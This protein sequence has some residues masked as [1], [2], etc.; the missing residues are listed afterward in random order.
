MATHLDILRQEAA[1]LP[2]TPGVYFW[3]NEDGRVLYIGKA[4]NLRA[5]V[6]SYFS[7]AQRDRRTRK[8]L[9]EARHIEYELTSTELEALFRESA[10][11]K[12]VLPE[13][14]RALRRPKA[15][16]YL[17][18]DLSRP[19][20]FMEIARGKLDDGALYFGPFPSGAITRETMA[21]LHDVLPLRKCTAAKPRCKP[22][23][24]FQMGKCAAP[25]IDLDHQLRH[26]EAIRRLH[27]FLDGR[28]DRVAGW[29]EKKRDRLS[30]SLLF[31][32]AADIQVRLDA[33]HDHRRQH[34]ILE[35]A[36][37]CRC[38]LI[39]D[40]G[41][42][43]A[44]ERLLLVAHGHVLSIRTLA[45]VRAAD[46]AGWVRAHES[47]IDAAEKEQGELDAASVLQR[48]LHCNRSLATWVAI[49]NK[50]AEDDLVDRCH[51]ILATTVGR[52][53]AGIA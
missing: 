24:Y 31:E 37:Q 6:T 13:F 50:A 25:L 34:A 1:A 19:H 27:D 38:V 43:A 52:E 17:K 40:P 51:Y 8:L 48:W 18:F 29:L 28:V 7:H 26:E 2:H 44:A 5:R 45:G 21:F 53:L 9:L 20:P 23:V 49:P 4:V 16:Y 41:K 42:E 46:L 35:A 11:I 47:V 30:E 14:N 32:H 12:Q 36:I 39:R 10:L 15:R 3:K 22:C 33:L